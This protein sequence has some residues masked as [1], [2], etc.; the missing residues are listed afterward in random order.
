MYEDYIEQLFFAPLKAALAFVR[1][2]QLTEIEDIIP[3]RLTFIL[4]L[5]FVWTLNEE[6]NEIV[7]FI[8]VEYK[9]CC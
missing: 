5:C 8:F 3:V 2:R 7:I 6:L 4:D 1:G 9:Q